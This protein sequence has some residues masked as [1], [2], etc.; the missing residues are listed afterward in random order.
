LHTKKVQS[1]VSLSPY[2]VSGYSGGQFSRDSLWSYQVAGR[3]SHL[4]PIAKLLFSG[5]DYKL[6]PLVVDLYAAM[7]YQI[8]PMHKLTIESYLSR[9]RYQL[10]DDDVGDLYPAIMPPFLLLHTM[11]F[12]LHFEIPSPGVIP[13]QPWMR[14][15]YIIF[16]EDGTWKQLSIL[17]IMPSVNWKI[18]F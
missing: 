14:N 2:F 15:P 17:P 6:S 12:F 11:E 13:I 5:S 1:S 10:S 4:Q 9:D 7:N 3:Y 16:Y 18:Q 8:T